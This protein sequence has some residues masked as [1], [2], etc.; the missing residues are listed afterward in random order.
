MHLNN[1]NEFNRTVDMHQINVYVLANPD[2]SKDI[3]P[4]FS[5]LLKTMAA[6]Q[7]SIQTFPFCFCKSPLLFFCFS[8]NKASSVIVHSWHGFYYIIFPLMFIIH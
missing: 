5:L 2:L 6:L 8:V 4:R 3:L 1:P 7:N